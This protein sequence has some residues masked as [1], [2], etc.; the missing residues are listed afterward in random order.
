MFGPRMLLLKADRPGT[1]T[2]FGEAGDAS[3]P[4]DN[5]LSL[6]RSLR[7]LLDMYFTPRVVQHRQIRLLPR[8]VGEPNGSM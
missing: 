6:D 1:N 5:I 8:V 7:D 4:H 3:Y 2:A